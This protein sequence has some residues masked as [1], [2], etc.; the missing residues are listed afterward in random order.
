MPAAAPKL[1]DLAGTG[2]DHVMDAIGAALSVPMLT[3]PHLLTFGTDTFWRGETHRLC[4]RPASLVRL[5]EE[6]SAAGAEQV[7][8]VSADAPLDRAHALSARARSIRG[9][10][11][12][13]ISPARRRRRHATR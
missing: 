2:R 6:V 12:P 5:L 13:T 11:S 10:C 1:V 4:D 3:E 9:R 8:L 7:I